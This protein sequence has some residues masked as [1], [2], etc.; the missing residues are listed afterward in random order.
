MKDKNKSNMYCYYCDKWAGKV[1][2]NDFEETEEWLD[3]CDKVG[4][5]LNDSQMFIP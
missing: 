4:E 3:I 5:T 1:V 2:S